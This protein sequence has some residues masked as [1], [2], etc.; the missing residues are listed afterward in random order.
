MTN[1]QC[2][3]ACPL[4]RVGVGAVRVAMVKSYTHSV[5]LE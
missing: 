5:G 1:L 2:G 4:I 3:Q